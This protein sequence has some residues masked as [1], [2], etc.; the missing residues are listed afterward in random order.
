MFR[1]L[2]LTDDELQESKMLTIKSYVNRKIWCQ[3][4]IKSN[5]LI[6][7][8]NCTNNELWIKNVWTELNKFNLHAIGKSFFLVLKTSFRSIFC[9]HQFLP[10]SIQIVI[11]FFCSVERLETAKN[12]GQ[13]YVHFEARGMCIL[14]LKI[15][16]MSLDDLFVLQEHKTAS[17][18]QW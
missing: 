14:R 2:N 6:G 16:A 12:A 18:M 15:R 5:C 7:E 1:I 4:L 3:I 9:S 13:G 17:N 8:K 10:Y 11:L